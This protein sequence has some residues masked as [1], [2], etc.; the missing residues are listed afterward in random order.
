MKV[1]A[2]PGDFGACGA[3]RIRYPW[4][5]SGYPVEFVVSS[6]DPRLSLADV[7]AF[8]RVSTPT[9]LMT[10]QQVKAKGKPVSIDFDDNLHTLPSTNPCALIYGNDKPATRM[11]EEALKIA[12][13]VTCS[14]ETLKEQYKRFRSDIIVVENALLPEHVQVLAP[15]MITGL[16]K[17]EGQ[18]RIGY[19]GSTTHLGDVSLLTKPFCKLAEQYDEV[20][21]VFMGQ[22]PV[23]P[24]TMKDY[25]QYAMGV[26]PNHEENPSDFMGRYLL[27][28]QALEL[29]I[30]VAPLEAHVFNQS[31]S[32]IKIL[33]YAL[34]GVPVVAS[35]VGPYRD[36]QN[37]GGAILTASDGREW[38]LRL[39]ELIENPELRK[40]LAQ[41][42]LDWVKANHTMDNTMEAWGKVFGKL[43]T[44]VKINELRASAATL[45][46]AP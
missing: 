26:A 1:A 8:Q 36:Y 20:I 21:F 10:M 32:F 44:M 42:N 24:P 35:S 23:L 46:L 43:E 5:N 41:T 40:E 37:R 4:Q 3:Y 33:E 17:K 16:P 28:L 27:A 15:E 7:V 12:D 34:C 45:T 13:V 25:V 2:C 30:A 9:G 19:A 11:F 38:K 6:N 31:K 14:T 18:I 29:D 22:L 39:S